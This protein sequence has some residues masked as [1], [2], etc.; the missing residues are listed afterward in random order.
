[1]MNASGAQAATIELTSPLLKSA[2]YLLTV[3][4]TSDLSDALAGEANKAVAAATKI[5]PRMSQFPP[6]SIAGHN[7]L[8]RARSPA[9]AQA[10]DSKANKP[11]A[12]PMSNQIAGLAALRLRETL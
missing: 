3:A 10:S 8:R 12:W 6:A 2:L 11:A 4:I 1:M 5:N 7:R 9:W